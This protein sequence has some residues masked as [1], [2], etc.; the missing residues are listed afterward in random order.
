MAPWTEAA[1]RPGSHSGRTLAV[2][3]VETVGARHLPRQHF[4]DPDGDRAGWEGALAVA[5]MREDFWKADRGCWRDKRI[6]SDR[7]DGIS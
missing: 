6:V 5:K 7:C 2:V 1:S 3:G 4:I